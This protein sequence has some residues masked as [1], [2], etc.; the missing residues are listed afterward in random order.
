M[1]IIVGLGNIGPKYSKTRHNIGFMVLDEL[2]KN[3]EENT[4]LKSLISKKDD[5]LLVK[6]TTLMNRSGEAVQKVLHYYKETPENLT[7]IYDDIDLPLGEIRIREKGS[8]GTHN[9]MK[10]V[11][12]HL[13]TE[14]FK[15]IRI[16]IESRGKLAPEQQDLASYVLSDFTKE[17]L[18][19]INKS[20]KE[21]LNSISS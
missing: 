21:V 5:T 4:K 13:G 19:T 10:S 20:M 18:K 8:A 2:S 14:N 15:R 16:G 7:V 11:I 3:F 6:P 12:E 1:K 17:E 9:G